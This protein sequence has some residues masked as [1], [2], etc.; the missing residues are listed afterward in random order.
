MTTIAGSFNLAWALYASDYSRYLPSDDLA[1]RRSSAARSSARPRPRSGSR[2]SAWPSSGR[3]AAEAD[4]VHQINSL[5]GGGIVGFL[6]MVAIFFGT[7]AVNA[8]NDYTGSLSLLAAGI[9]VKRPVSAAIVAVLSFLVTLYLYYNNFAIDGRELPAR[10]HLLDRAVGGDRDRRLAPPRRPGRAATKAVHF[11]MLPSGRNALIALVIGF[12]SSIPFMDQTLYVGPISPTPARRRHRLLSSAFIVAAV[13]YWVLEMPR[14][15]RSRCEAAE[16]TDRAGC[17]SARRA[18]PGADGRRA[19]GRAS[20]HGSRSP[21]RSRSTARRSPAPCSIRPS[22]AGRAR[23][24]PLTNGWFVS[25]NRPPSARARRAR[26]SSARP[27]RPASRS[28]PSR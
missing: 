22:R 27:R 26:A 5:V 8:M 17:P 7:V 3:S 24:R 4:T 19:A 9:R 21:R 11:S 20:R 6:A 1:E 28:R 16:P 10:H 23:G 14:R 2:P 12:S 25:M 13:V 18:A 15:A